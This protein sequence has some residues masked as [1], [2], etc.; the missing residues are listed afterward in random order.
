M[1]LGLFSTLSSAFNPL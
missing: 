1:G